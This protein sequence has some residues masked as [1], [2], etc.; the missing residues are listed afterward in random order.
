MM[1]TGRLAVQQEAYN[2]GRNQARKGGEDL[3]VV[4][5]KPGGAK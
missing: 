2:T 4:E 1:K 5:G 3:K